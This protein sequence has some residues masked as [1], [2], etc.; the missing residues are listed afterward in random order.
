MKRFLLSLS[1]LLVFQAYGQIQNGQFN[2]VRVPRYMASG[3]ST[4]LPVVFRATIVGLAPSTAYKYVCR[5]I[6]SSDFNSTNLY[7]GAGFPI[8]MDS[9]N[10]K[11][12]TSPNFTNSNGHDTFW[13]N[14]AGEYEGWFGFLYNS[15]TRFSKGNKIYPYLAAVGVL[16]NDTLRHYCQDSITVLAFGTSNSADSCTGIWGHSLAKS[17][18]FVGL[19]DDISGFGR[20]LSLTFIENDGVSMGSNLVSYYSSKV[21]GVNGN[22]GAIIPNVLSNG[23]RKI[24]NYDRYTGFPVYA[25]TDTDGIWGA[26]SKNT[27]NPKSGTTPI[28][29]DENDAALIPPD[30]QFWARTSTVGEGDGTKEIYV[31]RKYSNSN[32]SS[33][34]ISIVGGT[35][36]EGTG[37]D[38]KVTMPR[39]ITFPPGAQATDTTKIVIN[40]DASA[41]GNETIVLRLDQPSNCVI[42]TEVAHTITIIDNDTAR[43]FP[44]KTLIIAKETDGKVG[45]KIKVDKPMSAAST[46]RLI[47]KKQGDSSY[48]PGE[49]RLGASGKDTTFSLGNNSGPDST[50]IY[51]TIIDDVIGDPHDTFVLALRQISGNAQIKDSIITIVVRDNDGPSIVRFIGSTI[52]VTEKQSSV[53]VRIHVPYRTD[54][55]G[56]FTLRLLTSATT[57]TQGTGGDFVFS[58]SSKIINIDNSTPDTIVVNVPL[59]DDDDYEPTEKIVFGLG[60]LSNVTISKPDTF[61][62]FILNDDFPIYNIGTVNKQSGV[63]RTLDSANVKCRL[64]GIVYG[65]NVRN[66]GLQFTLIDNTGGISVLS[67]VKTFGYTVKEGDSV[68]VTGTMVQNQGMAQIAQLDTV[69]VLGTGKPLKNPSVQSDVRESSESQFIKLNRVKL[70]DPS[71]WPTA[72]LPANGFKIVKIAHTNGTEDSIL[73]D[74]ETHSWHTVSAPTGYINVTGI[75]GQMD[76]TSPFTVGHYISPRRLSDLEAATL[77]VV[78]FLKTSDTITELADSFRIDFVVAP[79][80][81]NFT[82]DVVIKQ[83]TAVSPKDYDYTTKT[84]QVIKNNSVNPIKVN[85]SDDTEGDGPKDITFA[86][87]NLKGPGSIGPDS[88][89]YLYILDNE[90]NSVKNFATGN[91]KMYPNPVSDKLYLNS[92]NP[93]KVVE[94]TS[95]DGKINFRRVFNSA[96]NSEIDLSDMSPGLYVIKVTMDSGDVYSE[97]LIK[98]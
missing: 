66:G 84:I 75:G 64:R 58:P 93:M 82:F 59:L 39:T 42:G 54:A 26:S 10:W 92:A 52:M 46:L 89:L 43:I 32:S 47:V 12:T 60:K 40:D 72:A 97:P 83:A 13:T 51:A 86:I 34:R 80:D 90:A 16:A 3:G 36:E 69:I 22:W 28:A 27:V 88:T 2:G 4:Q 35:A 48:I 73:L 31:V 24:E 49:F 18:S 50:T 85:I 67:S 45:I 1:T 19:Y 9:G 71:Q 14:G 61:T 77:P 5:G 29:L 87:R 74:A 94:V 91:I 37:K 7:V 81:E 41:E 65:G 21:E 44:A 25:N 30:I 70:S 96:L 95:I 38:Y 62:I 78:N 20:P 55:G 23:V 57:A 79:L 17:K 33:V 15:D 6:V 53:N 8:F 98:K 63:N 11:M 76:P 56:D 68:L